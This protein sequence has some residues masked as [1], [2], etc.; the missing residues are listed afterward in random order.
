MSV[1]IFFLWNIDLM[2]MTCVPTKS[3]RGAPLDSISNVGHWGR[4]I[5][6]TAGHTI[7]PNTNPTRMHNRRAW[8]TGKQRWSKGQSHK[9]FISS[10]F[11]KQTGLWPWLRGWTRYSE[12][13]VFAEM[14]NFKI[15]QIRDTA[16]GL[17]N[18]DDTTTVYQ[19]TGIR[20]RK[21]QILNRI[22]TLIR[23]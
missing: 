2:S 4:A 6:S 23:N 18:L 9:I 21:I 17:G 14:L 16:K 1:I 15:N 20:V 11:I 10:F 8:R 5:C 19:G 13:F 3:E 12:I 7:R 22:W